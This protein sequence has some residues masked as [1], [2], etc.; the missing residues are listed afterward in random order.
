M[1]YRLAYAIGFHPWEELA[2]HPPFAGKLLELVAR[3]EDRH[4]PP[5]GRALDLGAGSAVWGVR[6]A[7]RGWDV[8]CIDIVDKALRRARKRAD[9]AGADVRLLHAD[10]TALHEADLGSGAGSGGSKAIS[11]MMH[12]GRSMTQPVRI[13]VSR[14]F[15]VPLREGFDYITDPNNWPQYWP[16]LVR[17]EPGSRWQEPGD[18]ARLVLRLLGRPVELE[19]TLGRLAPYSVVEYASV[20][21]GL[22]DARHERLFED[23]D[24]DLV[25]RIVVSY[26]PRRGWRS[27]FDRLLVRRGIA[28]AA[29]KTLANLERRFSEAGAELQ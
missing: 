15:R 26:Q 19:M 25:Y 12:L 17:I 9:E 6:L 8:T 21:R 23:A 4:G 28:R 7:Q 22:P 2:E 14:R 24:G 27:V 3:E 1:N 20:Q 5:Y 10:V 11:P 16:D 18:R 29:R 13:E